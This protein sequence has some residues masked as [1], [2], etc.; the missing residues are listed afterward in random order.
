MMKNLIKRYDNLVED[1]K[2]WKNF[3][4]I[5]REKRTRRGAIDFDFA[6]AKIILN[7]VGKLLILNLMKEEYQIE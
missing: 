1:F 5:L 3:V 7:E 6:E 2:T 4:R